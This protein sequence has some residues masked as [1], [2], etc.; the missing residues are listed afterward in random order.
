[1]ASPSQLRSALSSEEQEVLL[2]LRSI[3]STIERVTTILDYA[4]RLTSP[5][6]AFYEAQRRAA[7]AL[8]RVHDLWETSQPTPELNSEAMETD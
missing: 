1:M 6:G 7:H 5:G 4:V 3:A 2:E 8:D